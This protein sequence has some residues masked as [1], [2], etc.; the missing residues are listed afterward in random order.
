MLSFCELNWSCI[1]GGFCSNFQ[2]LENRIVI[3]YNPHHGNTFWIKKTI[4]KKSL[5]TAENCLKGQ[6]TANIFLRNAGSRLFFRSERQYLQL[7]GNE[8]PGLCSLFVCICAIIV[9]KI[10]TKVSKRDSYC[11][12]TQYSWLNCSKRIFINVT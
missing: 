4:N 1:L 3:G 10:W 8:L 6:V 2:P 7:F 5:M 12:R 11:P 9:Q